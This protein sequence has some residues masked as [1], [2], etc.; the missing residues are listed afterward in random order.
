MAIKVL[1]VRVC[2][3]C[4][5][6]EGVCRYRVSKLEGDTRTVTV[7]LCPTHGAAME[8]TLESKPVP[9]RK[10]RAVTPMK[11]ITATRRKARKATKR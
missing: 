11:E 2:D 8:L 7:D 1:R 3:I 6:E 9:R 5:N 10:A 4:G